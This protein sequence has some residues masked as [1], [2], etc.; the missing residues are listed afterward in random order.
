[1]NKL[2]LIPVWFLGLIGLSLFGRGIFHYVWFDSGA[3]V[4]AGMDLSYPN[5]ADVVFLLGAAGALQAALGAIYIFFATKARQFIGFALWVEA[6]RSLF[7]VIMEFTF[8]MPTNLVP[9]RYVHSAVL[10]AAILAL[11]IYIFDNKKPAA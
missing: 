6:A 9:G 5:A 3:G 1:M 4:V 10:I 11:L 7:F 8:K 2:S